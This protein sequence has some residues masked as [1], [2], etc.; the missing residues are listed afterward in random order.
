MFQSIQRAQEG[1]GLWRESQ[2]MS[3]SYL[4]TKSLSKQPRQKSS[5]F[6]TQSSQQR[7][8]H[9]QWVGILPAT[10]LHRREGQG[11]AACPGL[12][13]GLGH[14]RPVMAVTRFF[15]RPSGGF[16][17]KE[18]HRQSREWL[19]DQTT[20]HMEVTLLPNTAV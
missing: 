4:K 3:Y 13:H 19:E 8:Q 2:L 10:G 11:N 5:G 9:K 16:M 18:P 20:Q 15:T 14:R 17:G 7:C 1:S 6:Y 12:P